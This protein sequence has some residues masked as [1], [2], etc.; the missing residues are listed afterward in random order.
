MCAP[1]DPD[2]SLCQRAWLPRQ[3]CCWTRQA[4]SRF[5]PFRSSSPILLDSV[6]FATFL[7]LHRPA[8]GILSVH[9]MYSAC[10]E[11]AREC[12]RR[13]AAPHSLALVPPPRGGQMPST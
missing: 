10:P 2:R 4:G 7:Q 3:S 13:G 1:L 9:M 6:H 5:S 12:N 11:S 8:H